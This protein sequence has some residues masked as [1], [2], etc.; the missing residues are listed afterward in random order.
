MARYIIALPSAIYS[1][2]CPDDEEMLDFAPPKARSFGTRPR[3][4]EQYEYSYLE[5]RWENGSHRKW[6]AV[7]TRDQFDE[8]VERCRLTAESTPTMGSIGAPGCGFGWQPAVSF[9]SDHPDA[10]QSAYVTPLPETRKQ[11]G[12]E[13]DWER[14]RSA[15]LAVYS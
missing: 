1:V 8:F 3:G 9:R 2:D 5:G 6:C 13:G 4:D 15:V 7:L 14:V 12:D 10:V 11:A